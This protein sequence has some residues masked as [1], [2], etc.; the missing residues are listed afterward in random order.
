MVEPV[1]VI[2]HVFNVNAAG[3]QRAR[4][5][6]GESALQHALDTVANLVAQLL[7]DEL[8]GVAENEG[9]EEV[10]NAALALVAMEHFGHSTLQQVP[11]SNTGQPFASP[12]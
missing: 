5:F 2:H 12:A 1:I 4:R 6:A 10:G 9:L 7:Q 3:P 8:E 11:A